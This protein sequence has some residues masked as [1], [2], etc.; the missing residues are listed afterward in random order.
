MSSK[1]FTIK[2]EDETKDYKFTITDLGNKKMKFTIS[3][4]GETFTYEDS[5]N[6]LKKSMRGFPQDKTTCAQAL[7]FLEEHIGDAF[8][9]S[10]EKGEVEVMFQVENGFCFTLK[11]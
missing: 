1:T 10:D 3:R 11:K 5:F 8:V 4:D 9:T 6:A 2:D 7:E